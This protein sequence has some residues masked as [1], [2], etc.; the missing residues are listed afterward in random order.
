MAREKF[1]HEDARARQRQR[2]AEIR[3][4]IKEFGYEYWLRYV[5]KQAEYKEAK[6]AKFDWPEGYFADSE[7]EQITKRELNIA[8]IM[9]N[10]VQ[11]GIDQE[12]MDVAME[13]FNNITGRDETGALYKVSN[14]EIDTILNDMMDSL[15][16]RNSENYDPVVLPGH[17]TTKPLTLAKTHWS[18][19]G[20]EIDIKIWKKASQDAKGIIDMIAKIGSIKWW[21][22]S[23]L[24]GGF[25]R[26]DGTYAEW[27]D[28]E[29][30][31]AKIKKATAFTKPATGIG[32][33]KET[34]TEKA[35]EAINKVEGLA[36]QAAE[37]D[38]PWWSI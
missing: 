33:R 11:M 8:L 19:E 9:E 23:F 24:P 3:A 29:R 7:G 32:F 36:I 15:L 35:I 22:R 31:K 30:R 4:F 10:M 20:V 17:P 18:I 38:R 37:E 34:P 26:R 21:A 27:L 12:W 13:E 2:Q 6:K 5:E 1:A 14:A 16:R 25:F 28:L